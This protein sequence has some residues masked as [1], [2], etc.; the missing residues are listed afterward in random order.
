MS[1]A[2]AGTLARALLGL[3]SNLGDRDA[4][5]AR[6]LELLVERGGGELLA[7]STLRT[8]APVGGPRQPDFRNGAALLDTHLAPRELLALLQSVEQAV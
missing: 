2:P 5:I 7:V 1:G 6:G 8:T 4:N 3:G